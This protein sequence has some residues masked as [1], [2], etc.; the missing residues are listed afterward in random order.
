M[1]YKKDQIVYSPL[2]G[3]FCKIFATKDEPREQKVPFPKTHEPTPP[4][5]YILCPFSHMNDDG[6]LDFLVLH[7]TVEDLIDEVTQ[8]DYD[9]FIEA[10][11]KLKRE[12]KD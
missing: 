9:R 2:L 12:K 7:E 10:Q 11:L 5:E 1:K 6:S 3:K 4:N 8:E